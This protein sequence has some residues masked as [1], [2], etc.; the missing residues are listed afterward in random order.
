M[1]SLASK[2]PPA[3]V[4]PLHSMPLRMT[5]V[6]DATEP[7]SS[8]RL[9]YEPLSG[10]RSDTHQLAP[11]HPSCRVAPR[12]R[13]G[14]RTVAWFAIDRVTVRFGAR[15]RG[16]YRLPEGIGKPAGTQSRGR[17]RRA[18]RKARL[19]RQLDGISLGTAT[20]GSAERR[21]HRFWRDRRPASH[22]RPGGR[23]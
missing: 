18:A 10:R 22:L 3:V 19:H 7:M 21:Q 17:A 1:V 15:W 16:P 11:R 20:A 2:P 5:F 23:R 4:W 13:R 9:L 6:V 12:R 14:S 8:W